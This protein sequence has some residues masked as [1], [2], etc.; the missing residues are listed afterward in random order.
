MALYI[1]LLYSVEKHA[2]Q[3]SVRRLRPHNTTLAAHCEC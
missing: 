3:K 2:F 1:N